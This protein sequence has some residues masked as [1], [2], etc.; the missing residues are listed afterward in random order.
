MT[1]A[2]KALPS[3][4]TLDDEAAVTTVREDY[5]RLTKEQKQLVPDSAYLRFTVIED[6]LE[7]KK[8]SEK[9]QQAIPISLSLK[10][11]YIV[12][13]DPE[14][15]LYNGK[16]VLSFLQDEYGSEGSY[17]AFSS[18]AD[19]DKDYYITTNRGLNN[20][21][22]S[23]K[24]ILDKYGKGVE[25]PVDKDIDVIYQSTKENGDYEADLIEQCDKCIFYNYEDQGQIVFYL[26]DSDLCELIIIESG[27]SF[28]A[29]KTIVMD[30]QKKLNSIGYDCGNPDGIAGEKTRN[31]IRKYQEEN[32]LFTSGI[33]DDGL[34]KSLET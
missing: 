26:N 22:P 30:V 7:T 5:D 1:K 34:L 14:S 32:G 31:A 12:S 29:D 24:A 33:I 16:N 8:E 21:Y 6:R 2:I 10:D 27:L 28:Y 20:N 4:I 25:I 11:F 15:I 18:V 13:T 17:W 19:M 3:K 9:Q 23:K